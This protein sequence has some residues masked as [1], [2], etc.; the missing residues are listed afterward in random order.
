MQILGAAEL[1]WLDTLDARQRWETLEKIMRLRPLAL[2]IS[3]DQPCPTDL[4]GIAEET[5]TAAVG[6]AEARP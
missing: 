1:A 3:Q 5:G 4:R 6:L 2:V